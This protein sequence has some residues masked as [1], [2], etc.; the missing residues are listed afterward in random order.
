MILNIRNLREKPYKKLR[1]ERLGF[2]FAERKGEKEEK[3]NTTYLQDPFS[4]QT[5]TSYT[6]SLSKRIWLENR[7]FTGYT[8]KLRKRRLQRLWTKMGMKQRLLHRLQRPIT[9][10]LIV[11]FSPHSLFPGPGQSVSQHLAPV[12]II[13]QW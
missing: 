13:L 7:N 5:Q 12:S 8:R 10:L 9:G 3:W 11:S 6:N 1:N 2:G 4:K